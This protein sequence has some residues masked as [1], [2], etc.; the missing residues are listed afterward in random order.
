MAIIMKTIHFFSLILLNSKK[1]KGF[2]FYL[3]ELYKIYLDVLFNSLDNKTKGKINIFFLQLK[4][5]L[6]VGSILIEIIQFISLALFL[7]K[8]FKFSSID[9]FLS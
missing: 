7:Y 5:L 9:I 3:T 1:L 2:Y 6:F 8:L 4:R